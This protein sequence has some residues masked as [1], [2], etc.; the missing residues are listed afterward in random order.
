MIIAQPIHPCNTEDTNVWPI[1]LLHKLSNVMVEGDTYKG[2]Q[3]LGDTGNK[4]GGS[5]VGRN[6]YYTIE[7]DTCKGLQEGWVQ[8]LGDIA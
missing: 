7:G 6:N 8:W 2:L 5:M 4:I 1:Q 3:W